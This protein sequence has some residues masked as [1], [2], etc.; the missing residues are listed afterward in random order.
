MRTRLVCA[1]LLGCAC[2]FAGSRPV[3]ARE[4]KLKVMMIFAHPDEG[5]IYTGGTAIL[6]TQMGHTVTFLSITNGDAGHYSMKP[7]DLAKRRYQE[8]MR[9]SASL[10]WPATRCWTITTG[11]SRTHRRFE[12]RSPNGFR[13]SSRM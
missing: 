13:I 11:T 6:Y 2:V 9:P 8:A 5:E 10:D 12:P 7:E 1:G 3:H 4:P